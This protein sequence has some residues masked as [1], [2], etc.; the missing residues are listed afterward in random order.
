MLDCV[1]LVERKKYLQADVATSAFIK[2]CAWGF[3]VIRSAYSED[4][5]QLA[6]NPYISKEKKEAINTNGSSLSSAEVTLT[7]VVLATSLSRA[8]VRYVLFDDENII[9]KYKEELTALIK[10]GISFVCISTTFMPDMKTLEGMIS[11]F[12]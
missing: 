1:V 8:K 9:S 11:F 3:D 10:K 5:S 7:G 6:P 12:H 2:A 4:I